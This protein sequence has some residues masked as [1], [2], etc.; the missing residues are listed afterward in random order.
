MATLKDI[1]KRISSVRST[2]KIT[3]AMKMVAAAKLRR[4]Q[5][6]LLE[7]RPY[8]AGLG[9]IIKRLAAHLDEEESPYL[10]RFE[11]E[12]VAELM[13]YSSD[14]GLC[15]GFNS[16]LLRKVLFFLN[17]EM[18]QFAKTEV[19]SIGKK[20]RDFFKSRKVS[21][22]QEITGMSETFNFLKA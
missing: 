7:G 15:G 4:A 14:R 17:F 12:Q 6:A 20:G 1:R 22:K 8:E 19:T 21:L 5:T 13:V 18:K 10:R 3:R 2:Q 11:G 9:D 16:N